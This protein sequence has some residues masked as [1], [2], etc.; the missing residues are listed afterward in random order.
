MATLGA[1]LESIE[2]GEGHIAL[3]FSEQLSQQHGYMHAGAISSIID[4]ACG[5]AALIKAPFVRVKSGRFQ[6]VITKL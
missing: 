2:E 5:Y 6:K 3:P 4:S 1:Q